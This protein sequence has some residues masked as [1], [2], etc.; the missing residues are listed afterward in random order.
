MLGLRRSFKLL[1]DLRSFQRPCVIP[2]GKIEIS[3]IGI[4]SGYSFNDEGE[5]VQ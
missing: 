5:G 4:K 1:D 3:E 2:V